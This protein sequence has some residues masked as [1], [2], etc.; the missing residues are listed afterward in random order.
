MG[1]NIF[2]IFIR[3]GISLVFWSK[4]LFWVGILLVLWSEILFYVDALAEP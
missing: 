1:I 4:I 2:K 3:G